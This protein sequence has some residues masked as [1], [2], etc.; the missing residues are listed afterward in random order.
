MDHVQNMDL[1]RLAA[2]SEV[3]WSEVR[4]SYGNF[5]NRVAAALVPV[6]EYRGFIYSDYAFRGLE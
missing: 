2:L 6:Y 1:P 3:S 4:D 5:V